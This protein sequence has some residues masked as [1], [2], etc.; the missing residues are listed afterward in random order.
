MLR[1]LV[2]I[3]GGM[4]ERGNTEGPIPCFMSGARKSLWDVIVVGSG[5]GGMAAAAALSKF[6]HKV[7]LLEQSDS[8]GGQTHSFV[9]GGFQWNTGIHYL[10]GFGRGHQIRAILDWLADRPIEMAQIEGVYDTLHIGD[11]APLQLSSSAQAQRLALKERFP[12]E[13][14]AIDAWFAAIHEGTKALDAI[15]KTRALP[16]A[17]A[18]A[19]RCWKRRSIRRWCRRTTAEVVSE[20]TK[21]PGLAAVFTAQWGDFGGR[22]STAS[23]AIHAMIIGLYM[24][25]GGWYPVGGASAIAERLLPTIYRAG[26]ESYAGVTVES[27]LLKRDRVVGVVTSNGE[28]GARRVVSD[29]GARET[30]DHLLPEDHGQQAWVK[31]IRSFETNICHYG[32]YLGFSG[33]IEAAGASKSNHW[34]YLT[35]QTDALWSCAPASR[36]PA[37]FVSFTSLKDPAH[38]PGPEQRHAGEL[39]AWADWSSVQRWADLPPGGRGADY[40]AFKRRTE[41]VL[42]DQFRAYFPKLAELVVFR[43]LSTPLTTAAYTGHSKGSFYG[44]E[45]TPRRVL[46]NALRSRTPI[47]GLYLA[48]QDVVT[49]GIPGAMWGGFLCAASIDP[50]VFQ[51]RRG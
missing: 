28:I 7:L 36:P 42:F 2:L 23:F 32:L 14:A 15:F 45:V 41:A 44:L 26:G 37:M 11:A 20:L 18:A 8:I 49:P 38:D 21:D 50:R 47:K 13:G 27:L 10:S 22:P 30:V 1:P 40:K 51:H 29:I 6:G 34:L 4:G 16:S 3:V 46:T 9:R 5:M 35:E 17:I 48:G 24:E 25:A 31:E 33:D 43:E 39:L 12:R 19:L